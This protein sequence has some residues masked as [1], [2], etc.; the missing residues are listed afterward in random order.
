MWP[1]GLI[2]VLL[3]IGSAAM[4]TWTGAHAI[5]AILRGITGFD[6]YWQPPV[7][8][9]ILG[10]FVWALLTYRDPSPWRA[11]AITAF[12]ATSVAFATASWFDDPGVSVFK[13]TVI[14]TMLAGIVATAAS[15]GRGDQ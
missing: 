6:E 7:G 3:W 15:Y 10:I 8:V 14:A 12:V 11:V 13:Q 9:A 2:W 4:V 1:F 5:V